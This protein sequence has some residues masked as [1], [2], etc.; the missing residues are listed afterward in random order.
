M[1]IDMMKEGKVMSAYG[2]IAGDKEGLTSKA[3]P[4]TDVMNVLG[5]TTSIN[6]GVD[7]R[8]SKSI[9]LSHNKE[10]GSS[11][12]GTEGSELRDGYEEKVEQHLGRF[13]LMSLL[14]GI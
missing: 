13:V 6:N 3:R 11:E 10:V 1:V 14:E 2:T 12:G 9:T 7:S 8:N 4:S 5:D